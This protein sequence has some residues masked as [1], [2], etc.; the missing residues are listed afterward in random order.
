MELYNGIPKILVGQDNWSLTV[1]REIRYI[2]SKMPVA[3]RTN[4]GWVIHGCVNSTREIRKTVSLTKEIF[5]HEESLISTKCV[6]Q[7]IYDLIK[8]H[9]NLEAIGIS[10][11]D[12]K[13]LN[14]ERAKSLLAT[15]SQHIDNHWEVPL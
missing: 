7:E 1:S 10:R 5:Y 15:F 8:S 13:N 6:D 12:R 2:N 11:H 4:L 3:S 14:L 9:F